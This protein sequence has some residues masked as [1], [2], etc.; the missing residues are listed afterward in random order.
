M[1]IRANYRSERVCPACGGS[2]VARSRRH[3]FLEAVLLPLFRLRPYR[4]R[5][6]LTRYFGYAHA[7]RVTR[8]DHSEAA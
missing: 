1:G 4:C 2:D 7:T 6:C 3:G 5:G 8:T